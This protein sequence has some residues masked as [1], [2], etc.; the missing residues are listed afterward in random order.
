MNRLLRDV[1]EAI[2][3]LLFFKNTKDLPY[4]L[5]AIFGVAAWHSII[6]LIYAVLLF[7]ERV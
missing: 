3:D 5:I 2:T 4:H 1:L 6:I 7:T